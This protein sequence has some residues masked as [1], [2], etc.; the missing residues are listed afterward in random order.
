MA[1]KSLKKEDRMGDDSTGYPD[2]APRQVES[3]SFIGETM[4][5]K[6]DF[7][8]DEDVIIEGNVT[9]NINVSK[10]LT[11]G[12]KGEVTADIDANRVRIIGFAKGTISASNKVEILS[13]G[14][15]YGNIK[16]EILVVEEGAILIGDIN[17]A[18]EDE[19]KK[20]S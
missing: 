12:K 9:G 11:I 2:I 7:N 6:G 1:F 17:K 8:S 5:I 10:T 19:K 3:G 13:Q 18:K 14:R 4:K 20:S 15:Y 16:S